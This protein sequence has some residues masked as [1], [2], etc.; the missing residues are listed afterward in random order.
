MQIESFKEYMIS[1]YVAFSLNLTLAS[2]I[3]FYTKHRIEKNGGTSVL[4]TYEFTVHKTK[5][6]KSG[7]QEQKV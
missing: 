6:R 4:I 2:S 1:D 7:D 3:V 5:R